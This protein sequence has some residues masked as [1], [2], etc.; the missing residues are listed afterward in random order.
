[1]NSQF[2]RTRLAWRRTI[3][4]V[5]AAGGLGGLHLALAGALRA[6]ILVGL[7][8][9]IGSALSLSR[10]TAL[11]HERTQP[12]WQPLA[13]TVSICLLALSVLARP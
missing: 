11:R 8:A 13:L 1:M 2:E 3:L 7:V 6:A 4:A 10:L 9:V 5:L 12:G